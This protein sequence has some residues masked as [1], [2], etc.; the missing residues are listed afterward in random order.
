MVQ[1][2]V[3]DT[4]IGDDIDDAIA[5]CFAAR[6]P[7]LDLL[8]VTTSC[9]CT[10]QRGR[11]VAKQLRLLGRDDVPYAPGLTLP[12][13]PVE[14]GERERMARRVP[15]EYDFVGDEEVVRPP[16][17]GDAVDL[18]YETIRAHDGEVALVSIGP[19]TNVAAL[20]QRHPDAPGRL[21]C[22]AMMAGE[23]P[24]ARRE[25]NMAADAVASRVVLRSDVPKWLGTW[26]VTR[27]VAMGPA[28]VAALRTRGD[29]VCQSLVEQIEMWWPHRGSKPG[30]VVYDVCPIV[31]CFRPEWFVTEPHRLDVVAD[32][33]DRGRN[34]ASETAPLTEV[35][36]DVEAPRVLGML[37]DT[38]LRQQGSASPEPTT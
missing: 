27:R 32:G 38:L 13:T 5:L 23:F 1:K 18:M 3:L 28:D 14:D 11:M 26:G 16:A 7:E 8:A 25:Y 21:K 19:L 15:L 22:L 2:I 37:M 31:W 29:A 24:G 10:H 35:T 17:C 12:L 20:L 30:P 4:D 6:R 36:A 34:V 33:P 9:V